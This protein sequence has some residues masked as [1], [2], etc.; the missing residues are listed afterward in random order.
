MFQRLGELIAYDLLGLAAGSAMQF[1]ITDTAKI[2]A[3]LVW[4]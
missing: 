1:L 2:F 3:L 4:R